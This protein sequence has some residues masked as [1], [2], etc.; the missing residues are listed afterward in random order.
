MTWKLVNRLTYFARGIW[1]R[2][3]LAHWITLIM[4]FVNIGLGLAIL[5]GGPDRFTRPTYNPLIE[6]TLNHTY[7]WGVLI[8][9]AAFL[10]FCKKRWASITGLWISMVWHIVWMAAFLLAALHYPNSAVTPIPAYCGFAL[11]SAALLTAR[12]IEDEE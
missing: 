2:K 12:V 11:I 3:N 5:I 6:Y 7:I 1:V 10:M 9:I 4:V 8:V